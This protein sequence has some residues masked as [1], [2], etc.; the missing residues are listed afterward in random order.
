M[1]IHLVT[2]M[3]ERIENLL[4]LPRQLRIGCREVGNDG[5]LRG[6]GFLRLAESLIHRED[7]GRP[8]DGKGGIKSLRSNMKKAKRLLRGRI[9]P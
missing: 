3:F 8:E 4:G 5:L 7:T 6:E 1:I 2:N 9:A